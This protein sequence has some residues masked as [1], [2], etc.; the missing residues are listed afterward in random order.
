MAHRDESMPA[1]W[2]LDTLP[3]QAEDKTKLNKHEVK[4]REQSLEVAVGQQLLDLAKWAGG[5]ARAGDALSIRLLN[6]HLQMISE[7]CLQQLRE[8]LGENINK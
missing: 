1:M 5:R 3:S 6:E 8:V 2:T 4:R 7:T